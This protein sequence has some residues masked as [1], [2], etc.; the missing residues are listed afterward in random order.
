MKQITLFDPLRASWV[1]RLLKRVTSPTTGNASPVSVGCEKY[2]R[3]EYLLMCGL[4]LIV[5]AVYYQTLCTGVYPG[6][7]AAATG[8]VL[9]LLPD[10]PVSHPLWLSVSRA[11]AT[12]PVFIA[13]YWL[14]LFTAFC[15]SVAVAWLFRIVSRVAFELIRADPALRFVPV[16][17]EGTET[18]HAQV[19]GADAALT[20]DSDD[21]VTE[22]VAATLGGL[23]SALVFAFCAPFWLASTSLH[24]QPLDI[25]LLLFT[26]DLLAYYHF[27]GKLGTGV[28]AVF[29]CGA[30]LIES[31]MFLIFLPFFAAVVIL[32]CIRYKQI[33]E[34]FLLLLLAAGLAGAAASLALLFKLSAAEQVV[35]MANLPQLILGFARTYRTVLV[36][37]VPRTDGL[38]VLILPLLSLVMAIV[39]ARKATV[40]RDEVTRWKWRVINAIFSAVVIAEMLN[41]PKTVWTIARE[42]SHLPI[43]PSLVVAVAVGVF[44]VF[45]HQMSVVPTY[46]AASELDQPQPVTRVIGYGMCGLLTITALRAASLNLGDADG[47]TAAF[48]DRV[49][50]EMLALSKPAQC[51]VTDGTLDLN[52]LIRTH[53]TGRRLT[54]IPAGSGHRAHAAKTG[55]SSRAARL[56]ITPAAGLL[57]R[58]PEAVVEQWLRNN[59]TE[60]TH[61]ATVGT[62]DLWL[63]AGLIPIPNGL[64]YVGAIHA[65]DPDHTALMEKSREVWQRLAALLKDDPSMLPALR[66][67]QA[68][69]RAHVSRVANDLG[70]C[71]E[72]AGHLAEADAVYTMSLGLDGNNLCA[73][74]NR[75][76]LRM[77]RPDAG[78]VSEAACQVVRLAEEPRLVEKFAVTVARY[79]TLAPQLADNLVPRAMANYPSGVT[80][81][82]NL[83]KLLDKWLTFSQAASV[84]QPPATIIPSDP[85]F[86]H[87]LQARVEGRGDETEKNVR[88]IV[89]NR[90]SNL[91]AWSLLA[92]ILLNRGEVKEVNDNI[93]PAM[94]AIAGGVTNQLVEMIQGCLHMRADPPRYDAARVCFKHVLLLN[95]DFDVASE[96]LLQ[97]DV[98]LGNAAYIEADALAVVTHNPTHASANALLGGVRLGQRRWG[99]AESCLR[100]SLE[101]R[102]S[103]A[104]HN[105]L[106]ELFRQQKK[107]GE[108]EQQARLAIRLAPGF[109]QAWDSLVAALADSGRTEEANVAFQCALALHNPSDEHAAVSPIHPRMNHDRKKDGHQHIQLD[110]RPLSKVPT[111]LPE[112]LSDFQGKERTQPLSE[113]T[114]I[115]S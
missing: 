34:S 25:L 40:C 3:L 68:D 74:L 54:I 71:L 102:P 13:P 59:P 20:A 5:F 26:A 84:T 55:T 21:D 62:P 112:V 36:Q 85:Q 28:A 42:G 61:F 65:D 33:S 67:T 10:V 92:E 79:G 77:R 101:R 22:H 38:F 4:G 11:V 41:L 19:E 76:G 2:K 37:S 110:E 94:R 18:E 113:L 72:N 29:L 98:C 60:Y 99:E 83:I 91:S 8:K 16:S 93:F 56:T 35:S 78:P 48:A 30:G 51:L 86:G 73:I 45:W 106:S 43:L 58:E 90:P 109:C 87:A 89:K 114:R 80:P 111:P 7:S 24:V 66:R 95:P 9:G 44:F 88:R 96:R 75:Y 31:P 6:T 17:D 32:A 105:D 23:V 50:Q 69:V 49:A 15:G 104:A 70:T 46:N 82:P 12:L 27:T 107:W 1:R 64:L 47:R 100:A 115:E 14:N 97:A 103:A 52:L 53:V 57:N 81:I 108:A 39:G 63:R